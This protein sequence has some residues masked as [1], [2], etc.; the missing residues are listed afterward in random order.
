MV[1]TLY[2]FCILLVAAC[3]GAATVQAQAD[4]RPGY[5][6]SLTGDTLR[7]EVALQGTQ[8]S[9]RQCL[10]RAQPTEAPRV[11]LPGQLKG[12]GL[13]GIKSYRTTLVQVGDTARASRF[14][15]LLVSGEMSLLFSSDDNNNPRFFMLRAGQAVP[16]EL[17]LIVRTVSENDRVYQQQIRQY[18]QVLLGAFAKYPTLAPAIRRARFG[19]PDLVAL[20]EQYNKLAGGN[21]Q[22][23][24]AAAA[25]TRVRLGVA[26]SS[27][28][29]GRMV[30]KAEGSAP[31]YYNTT[32]SMPATLAGGVQ[33]ALNNPRLSRILWVQIGAYYERRNYSGRADRGQLATSLFDD[34]YT[35]QYEAAFVQLPVM[36]RLEP[37]RGRVQPVFEAGVIS[38]FRLSQSSNEYSIHYTNSPTPTKRELFKDPRA[39]EQGLLL[40]AGVATGLPGQHHLTALLRYEISS[41]VSAASAISSTCTAWRVLLGY[42]L[43]G[44]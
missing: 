31:N 32:L 23:S 21:V 26:V 43:I 16:E 44:K 1:R 14:L 27:A 8:R 33:L 5:I 35:L 10:F 40:G 7:G 4:F 13:N 24:A 29:S 37:G 19:A 34:Y 25:R 3:A 9:L 42:D 38:A 22:V 20:F 6:V 28:L 39:Y 41:G 11:Y 15:E 30:L 36:L 12:Y 2:L 17:R 18:Q